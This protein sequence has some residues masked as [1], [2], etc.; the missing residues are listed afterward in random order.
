MRLNQE[1]TEQLLARM[2]MLDIDVQQGTARWKDDIPR[3][4]GLA[5]PGA[6]VTCLVVRDSSYHRARVKLKYIVWLKE[7]GYIPDQLRYIDRSLVTGGGKDGIGN[8]REV[9]DE[10]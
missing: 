4:R 9:R 6:P 10:R 3:R 2:E 8:L 5:K 7:Y 1:Q